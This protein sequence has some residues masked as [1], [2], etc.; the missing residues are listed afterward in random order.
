MRLRAPIAVVGLGELGQVLAS[1]FLKLGH[2]V[3]P[4]NRDASFSDLMALSIDPLLVV[5]AVGEKDLTGV[6][7]S[8]PE[9]FKDRIVLL[10]NNLLEPD[11]V[12]HGVLDPTILVVWLDKKPGRPAVSV[13]PNKVFGPHSEVVSQSLNALGIESQVR[14]GEELDR[15]LVAKNLYIHTI[16]IAGLRVGGTVG[17]LWNEHRPLAETIAGEILEIQFCRLGRTL[18]VDLMMRDMLEGFSGDLDHLCMGR[19]AP[20]RLANALAFANHYQLAVPTLRAIAHE[21]G[22]SGEEAVSHG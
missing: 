6:L 3:Y 13:L 5:V 15:A 10:Q 19:S 21:I 9:G 17:A 8:L 2:P 20:N 4:L 18:D 12:N 16:N 7:L 14:P 22:L 1:G 11:W